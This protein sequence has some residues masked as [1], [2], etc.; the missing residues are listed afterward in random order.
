MGA[1]FEILQL[2][3][4]RLKV[5]N[6]LPRIPKNYPPQGRTE[7]ENLTDLLQYIIDEDNKEKMLKAEAKSKQ[8]ES[9]EEKK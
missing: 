8:S 7:F 5:G 3:E 9:V 2:E 6:M 1:S 4:F